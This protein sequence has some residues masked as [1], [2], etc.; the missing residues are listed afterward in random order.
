MWF[1]FCGY[2]RFLVDSIM[3]ECV[4]SEDAQTLMDETNRN[5]CYKVGTEHG[6]TKS[7]QQL[8]CLSLLSSIR[9]A[10]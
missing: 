6:N 8:P 9:S 5:K 4:Y 10:L 7:D 3:P 2:N 1:T